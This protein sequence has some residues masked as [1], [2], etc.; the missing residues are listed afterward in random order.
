MFSSFK[1]SRIIKK[2]VKKTTKHF[3]DRQPEI[4]FH[5]FYGAVDI[6]PKNLSIWYIFKTN[7]D[8]LSAKE[9]GYCDEIKKLTIEN[10]IA[11]GYPEDAFADCDGRKAAVC[12][13]S[14]QDVDE[15]ADGDYRIYFQ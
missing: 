2:A 15:K 12:F 10:L 13:T 1:L 3:K 4:F 9:S 6:S 8:L 7:S 14:Q 5:T 11:C